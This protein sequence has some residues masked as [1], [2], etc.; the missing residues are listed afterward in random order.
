MIEL[1]ILGSEYKFFFTLS[2]LDIVLKLLYF[3][4]KMDHPDPA[5]VKKLKANE[6]KGNGERS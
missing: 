5:E 4:S 2:M 6:C 3:Y 1:M